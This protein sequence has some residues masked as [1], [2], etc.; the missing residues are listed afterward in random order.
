MIFLELGKSFNR[1]KTAYK[2]YLERFKSF[3][4]LNYSVVKQ[5]K[6]ELYNKIYSSFGAQNTNQNSI[7]HALD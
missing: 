3:G 5:L 6:L 2:Y 4:S 1:S 7:S